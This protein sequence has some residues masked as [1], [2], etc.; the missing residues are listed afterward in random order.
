MESGEMLTTIA[1][2]SVALAGFGGIAAGLGYR[3][4]GRWNDQDRFRL[5]VMVAV[6]LGIVF[7]C[8]VPYSFEKVGMPSAWRV[9]SGLVTL[10]P[11][12]NLIIQFR[13]FRRGLP[14]GFSLTTTLSI[15]VS[16]VIGLTLLLALV[17]GKFES[18]V[19]EGFYILS[20]L[21]LLVSPAILFL[22]LIITSFIDEAENNGSGPDA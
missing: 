18:D 22:R 20:I 1:E 8:L 7:A 21:S 15:L 16:N 4:H 2:V 12:S 11:V 19:E 10:I 3:S 17:F 5:L 14:E 9:S 6:S 13:L